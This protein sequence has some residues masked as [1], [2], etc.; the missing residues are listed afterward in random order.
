MKSWDLKHKLEFKTLMT[1]LH[2]IEADRGSLKK[3]IVKF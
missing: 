3:H 1:V 2:K